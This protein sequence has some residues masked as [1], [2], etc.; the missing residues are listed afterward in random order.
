M[1]NV[2]RRAELQQQRAGALAAR[3]ESLLPTKGDERVLD[4]G[5]GAGA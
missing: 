5:A 4:V 2:E 1:N 3:L